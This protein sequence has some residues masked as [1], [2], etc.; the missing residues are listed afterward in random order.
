MLLGEV[1]GSFM[2]LGIALIL[3]L[4]GNV[5]ISDI[6][7]MIHTGLVNPTNPV[8]LFAAGISDAQAADEGS[9]DLQEFIQKVYL[10]DLCYY[11][12]SQ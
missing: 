1:G 3:G 9:F 10:V 4:T 2:L 8:L 6:V 7:M 11:N 5:N 12:H